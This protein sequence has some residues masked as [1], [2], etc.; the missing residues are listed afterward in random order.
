MLHPWG[1]RLRRAM[2]VLWCHPSCEPV[3]KVYEHCPWQH[4]KCHSCAP[5]VVE[6]RLQLAFIATKPIQAGDEITWDYG[7]R[8][9]PWLS[10][11]GNTLVTFTRN[12]HYCNFQFLTVYK[13]LY[14]ILALHIVWQLKTQDNLYWQGK[15]F[16]KHECNCQMS[17][18]ELNIIGKRMTPRVINA[19]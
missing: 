17:A 4:G 19:F 16:N 18:T 14:W 12:F 7:V 11:Q 3:W 2:V 1:T 8:G 9:E 13:L 10:K 5:V 15:L 6:G